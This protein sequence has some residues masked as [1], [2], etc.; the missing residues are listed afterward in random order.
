MNKEK[1]QADQ[2]EELEFAAANNQFAAELP[3]GPAARF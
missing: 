3:K 1:S 2:L